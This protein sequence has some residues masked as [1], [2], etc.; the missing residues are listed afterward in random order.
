MSSTPP[1]P[2]GH[3]TPPGA[4]DE[5][6][7][8]ATLVMLPPPADLAPHVE[9]LW[10]LVL[11]AGAPAGACWRVVA[12]GY[13]DLSVRTPLDAEPLR[14]V[15]AE[16]WRLDRRREA[17]AFLASRP[18]VVCNA[19]TTARALPM[20]GPLLVTGA[21]F[22]LGAVPALLRTPALALVDGARPLDDVVGA[23][24]AAAGWAARVAVAPRHVTGKS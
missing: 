23:R 9:Y 14:A 16:P 15:S 13:V 1:P 19:A 6:A 21:R 8:L 4:L 22:R 12:D 7:P 18:A 20:D 11:A 10:Q 17:V 5:P 24:A 3:P 2:T